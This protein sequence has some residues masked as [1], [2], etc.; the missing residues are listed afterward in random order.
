[1]LFFIKKSYLARFKQ[2]NSNTYKIKYAYKLQRLSLMV[3]IGITLLLDR[4]A[5]PSS[6]MFF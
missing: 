5:F 2:L 3:C 6:L 4:Q 1:M